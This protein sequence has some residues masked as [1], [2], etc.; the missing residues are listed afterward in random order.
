MPRVINLADQKN[1]WGSTTTTQ[2]LEPQRS[3]L[4]I[5]DF[6]DVVKG[7]NA[8][9]IFGKLGLTEVPAF[10]TQFVQSVTLPE[11]KMKSEVFRRDSVPF[12]MPSWDE[13]I[14]AIKIVF[15]L[16]A[17]GDVNDSKVLA[18][19]KAWQAL[20]RAGRGSRSGL[21]ANYFLPLNAN[22]RYDYT[23]P[24]RVAL[25]RGGSSSVASMTAEQKA[26][27][28]QQMIDQS[29]YLEGIDELTQAQKLFQRTF[30]SPN[31]L[32]WNAFSFIKS[33][34]KSA[35]NS[36]P[37]AEVSTLEIASEYRLKS[38][39]LGGW[40]LGDLSYGE[41]KLL[42]VDATLYAESFDEIV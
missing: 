24:V 39:W 36:R 27:M 16:D 5:V 20:V 3:D 14:D 37:M 23:F 32:K 4:W 26:Q 12:Q 17:Y 29:K 28:N 13:P 42:T 21:Y 33:A 31:A 11:L 40:K 35:L 25:L 9:N 7:L 18:V 19:L 15:L 1:L 22:F 30:S 10:F 8:Q 41:S 2:G 34:V 38:V 6:T